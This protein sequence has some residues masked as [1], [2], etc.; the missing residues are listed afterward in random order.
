MLLIQKSTMF[1]GIL[2]KIY[3]LLVS[4]L[5]QKYKM[6]VVQYVK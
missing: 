4:K 5:T 3:C 2:P 1:N 6:Q